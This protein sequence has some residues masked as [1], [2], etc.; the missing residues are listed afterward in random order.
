MKKHSVVEKPSALAIV[1]KAACAGL[2]TP[3]FPERTTVAGSTSPRSGIH[4]SSRTPPWSVAK[5]VHRHARR[6]EFPEDL[7][8]LW[9]G[10]HG[11]RVRVHPEQASGRFRSSIAEPS[12]QRRR[13]GCPHLGDAERLPGECV[14]SRC[15]RNT[16]RTSWRLRPNSRPTSERNERSGCASTPPMSNTTARTGISYLRACAQYAKPVTSRR[17]IA[18]GR[19]KQRI[20]I[21]RE[22]PRR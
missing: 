20:A 1:L 17:S 14:F 11:L 9:N 4:D 10:D 3:I 21:R 22:R 19:P 13:D 2:P 12:R 16:P 7:H 8:H 15:P 6:L 18:R 5:A